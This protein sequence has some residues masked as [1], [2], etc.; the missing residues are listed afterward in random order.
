MWAR[1]VRA[2][3]TDWP[4][5]AWRWSG[6][7]GV[8]L[9]ADGDVRVLSH[10]AGEWRTLRLGASVQS[11]AR[12]S[13]AAGGVDP[14]APAFPYV[15]VMASLA[16]ALA[17]VPCAE[18][19]AALEPVR[20]LFLG[21]GACSLPRLLESALAPR[22]AYRDGRVT[23]TVVELDARVAQA[24]REWFG[25][26]AGDGTLVQ[27]QIADA[28]SALERFAGADFDLVCVDIFGKD[29]AQPGAFATSE[30]WLRQVRAAVRPGGVV[31]ANFHSGTDEARAVLRDGLRAYAGVFAASS[32]WRVHEQ[33]NVV[34]AAAVG[35]HAAELLSK[36]GGFEP[37]ALDELASRAEL[38][39]RR[40]GWQFDVRTALKRSAPTRRA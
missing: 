12:C 5:S 25:V 10:A 1:G 2:D 22:A 40:G 21:G 26:G 29:N 34:V 15:K 24:A 18:S 37:G 30:R 11:A 3:P 14:T 19:S 33:A 23:L 35:G 7:R 38:V 32:A 8:E 9:F 28:Q 27:I 4:S 17:L 31:L 20:A 13:R 16:A 39:A 6:A 36:A